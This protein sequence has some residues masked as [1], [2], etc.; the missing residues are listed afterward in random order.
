MA[1]NSLINNQNAKYIKIVLLNLLREITSKFN[2][3][4][5]FQS[6]KENLFMQTYHN[7]GLKS[8]SPNPYAQN[9]AA[10]SS[11]KS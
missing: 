10:T 9:K 5:L 7:P 1:Y 8:Y 2:P 11:K 3:I 6:N 4:C